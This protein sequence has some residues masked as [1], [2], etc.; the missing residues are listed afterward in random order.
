M[1]PRHALRLTGLLILLLTLTPK[2][3]PTGA[4][5]RVTIAHFGLADVLVNIALFI[6]F[7]AALRFSG[8]RAIGVL[9]WAFTLSLCVEAL[10]LFLP[11][12]YPSLSDLIMNT[13]GGGLGGALFAAR[14]RLLAPDLR[15]TRVLLVL[16]SLGLAALMIASPYLME[17]A[18]PRGAPY[19][20]YWRLTRP[21]LVPFEG[22]T[23]RVTLAGEPLNHKARLKASATRAAL[24]R[25]APLRVEAE[26]RPPKAG[27]AS[28]FSVYDAWGREVVL[29][30]AYE[31][32]L[33]VRFWTRAAPLYLH[34]RPLRLPGVLPEGAST[35]R[36][37]ATPS[38]GEVILNGRRYA[39]LGAR[40]EH[41]WMLILHPV[42]HRLP[43][44]LPWVAALMT[45]LGYLRPR[46]RA[47]M[48][49]LLGLGVLAALLWWRTALTPSSPWA[50]LALLIGLGLGAWLR[51]RVDLRH[52][53]LQLDPPL[54]AG[55]EDL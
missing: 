55:L 35:L 47:L 22:Q 18:S 52:Q 24:A 34:R 23:R 48:A 3:A 7:G 21:H 19:T 15:M 4:I 27:L 45:P 42:F 20:A 28:I 14:A 8:R 17:P 41:S 1:S 40:L 29:I 30:G 54:L 25:G 13:L 26:G 12:R 11:G 50:L 5:N 36:I 39:G 49:L 46:R 43:L 16:Y 53:R 31:R 51:R 37:E 9:G 32:D 33:I 2:G 6:P 38:R 44:D 10:Q